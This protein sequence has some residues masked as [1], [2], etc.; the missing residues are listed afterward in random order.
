MTADQFTY[1]LQ[2]F[3]ELNEEPPSPEQWK[4]ICDHLTLVFNK[5]TPHYD[6]SKTV[7]VP[8]QAGKPW[9]PSLGPSCVGV[10]SASD[11]VAYC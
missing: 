1:W 9:M 3:A 10:I 2:G 8:Y 5:V 6:F 4:A 11:C 7:G